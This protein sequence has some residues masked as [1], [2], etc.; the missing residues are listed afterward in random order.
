VTSPYLPWSKAVLGQKEDKKRIDCRRNSFW[1]ALDVS[2]GLQTLRSSDK[3]VNISL[4][5]LIQSFTVSGTLRAVPVLGGSSQS[6][7][8]RVLYYFIAESALNFKRWS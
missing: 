1:R 4:S 3:R 8:D 7:K 5:Y 6:S 2:P